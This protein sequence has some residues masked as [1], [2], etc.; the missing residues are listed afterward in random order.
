MKT[1]VSAALVM[2]VLTLFVSRTVHASSDN[3]KTTADISYIVATDGLIT[4]THT[5]TIENLTTELYV[6]KFTLKVTGTQPINPHAKEDNKNLLLLSSNTDDSFELVVT[7]DPVV[8]LGKTRDFEIVFETSDFAF[9]SGSV[10]EIAIPGEVGNNVYDVT[11]IVLYTPSEF[12][13]P[14][15]ISPSPT[16]QFQSADLFG[17]KFVSSDVPQNGLTAAFGEFQM[18]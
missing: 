18:F 12:G 4:V 6:D 2:L 8:G 14:A 15:Y 3:F 11:S 13:K 5:I 10:W 9:R 7:L 1:L 17:F 16:K